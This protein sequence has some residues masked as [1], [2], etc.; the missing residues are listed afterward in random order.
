MDPY[1]ISLLSKDTCT[2]SD[3][4]KTT[5][6]RSR[7]PGTDQWVIYRLWQQLE[8]SLPAASEADAVM[9]E[10]SV[11]SRT[12]AAT[13]LI[14]NHEAVFRDVINPSSTISV[15]G[16]TLSQPE[17]ARA[18]V[19]KD[20]RHSKHV[21]AVLREVARRL[22]GNVDEPIAQETCPEPEAQAAMWKFTAAFLV[23]RLQAPSDSERLPAEHK[24]RAP[25]MSEEAANAMRAA[26]RAV[27]GEINDAFKRQRVR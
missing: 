4:T 3:G 23:E 13:R 11:E 6:V 9:S 12:E 25:D 17:L 1:P 21:D 27:G 18:S 26:L 16:K 10:F 5:M 24:R 19:I 14:C 7:P 15:V 22:L 2:L 20:P 8:S